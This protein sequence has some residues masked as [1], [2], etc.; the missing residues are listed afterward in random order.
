[1]RQFLSLFVLLLLAA[2]A[3]P[4]NAHYYKHGTLHPEILERMKAECL[5]LG[6]QDSTPAMA[7]CRKDLAQDWKYNI[8]ANRRG[9]DLR[10]SFGIGYGIGGRSGGHIGMGHG[11]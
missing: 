5:V 3:N 7:E 1:M 4:H 2:C 10:P 9:R 8:E 6:F 11:W